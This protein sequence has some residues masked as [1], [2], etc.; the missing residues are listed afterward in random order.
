[1]TSALNLFAKAMPIRG[2][3]WVQNLTGDVA[4]IRS[5]YR[6]TESGEVLM[7]LWMY[8]HKGDK[9]GRVSPVEGGPRTFEPAVT[10]DD[11]WFRIHPPIFP[12]KLRRQEDGTYDYQQQRIL[13]G[14]YLPRPPRVEAA[15]HTLKNVDEANIAT[16]HRMAAQ[17]LRETIRRKLLSG[18]A[19]TQIEA[20]IAELER[21]ADAT[22]N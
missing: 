18:E 16:S 2:N 4:Q 12:L 21:I 5:V 3:G 17:E 15:V 22:D 8:S 13:D 19:K 9:L 10:Y 20:R 1:M 6:D 11:Y 14:A 7:D